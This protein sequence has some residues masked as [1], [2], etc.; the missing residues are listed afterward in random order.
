MAATI[1]ASNGILFFCGPTARL[2]SHALIHRQR[3]GLPRPTSLQLRTCPVDVLVFV[4]CP[5]IAA[6]DGAGRS[7]NL[8]AW[9][10]ERATA[11]EI[12]DRVQALQEAGK[13]RAVAAAQLS[14][15]SAA[16]ARSAAEQATTERAELQSK[17]GDLRRQILAVQSQ[18]DSL[19]PD[20]RIALAG[21][22]PRDPRVRAM[23]DPSASV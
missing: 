14:A 5:N 21:P 2:P 4:C 9:A 3:L 13:K 17:Q 18:Y 11:I 6:R 8:M 15:T 19:T 1:A 10:T 20:Q 7:H 12:S 23:P 22:P 16:T